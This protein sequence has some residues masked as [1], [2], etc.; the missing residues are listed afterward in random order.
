MTYDLCIIGGAGHAGLP[1]ALAFCSK[2]RSVAVVDRN[3]EALEAIRRGRMPFS[4][5]GAQDFLTQA[6]AEGRLTLT[7]DAAAAGLTEAVIIIV[8]TPIDEYLNPELRAMEECLEGL[9][10]HLHSG[11]LLV[12]RSTVYPGVSEWTLRIL[13]RR[14]LR[15]HVSFCPERTAE[16]HAMAELFLL[17]Q[18]V[19]AFSDEGRRRARALFE[20]IA[21]EIVE[22]DPIEAELVK[23]FSNAWRYLKF[24]TSNQF[25]MIAND[26]GLDFSRIHH[27]IT[28]HYP[29]AADLPRPGFAAGPCLFKD[30]MQLA[31]FN[32]NNFALG[33]AAML[34]NEG[35][36]FYVVSRLKA[37]HRLCDMTAG[38]LGMAFKAESDDSRASLSYKLKKQLLFECR[39]VLTTDPYVRD[40]PDLLPLAEVIQHSDL[41]IVGTPHKVYKNLSLDGKIVVD[42]WNLFGKG[43]RI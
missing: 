6:L 43:T 24:A 9:T 23:L 25:Y 2:G 5:E 1:L 26:L 19:S 17:P 7:G 10:P 13:E 30:T 34:I 31:A 14:G 33:Q 20:S 28:Y 12:L 37:R 16:G 35:L 42:V 38:I 4:E 15:V 11:Q 3:T 32:N 21:P 36:V 18:I 39:A 8:G 22:I 27:A 41:L 40:D 29:R